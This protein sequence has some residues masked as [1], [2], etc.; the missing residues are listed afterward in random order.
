[1]FVCVFLCMCMHLL[2]FYIL[3]DEAGQ[4]SQISHVVLLHFDV[5]DEIR[6]NLLSFSAQ[7]LREQKKTTTFAYLEN[8]A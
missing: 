7:R 3:F 4:L 8:S 2:Y 5:L 6:V 1:M